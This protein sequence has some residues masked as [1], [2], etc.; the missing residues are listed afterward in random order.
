M[1]FLYNDISLYD[2]FKF[3]IT[4]KYIYNMNYIYIDVGYIRV[5][6]KGKSGLF[7]QK[8]FGISQYR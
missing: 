8:F 1:I 5:R 2:N 7:V 4:N 6:Y 3:V